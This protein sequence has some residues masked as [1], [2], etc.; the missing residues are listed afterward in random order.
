MTILDRVNA[1]YE[2][3]VLRVPPAVQGT[4]RLL[5]ERGYVV[6]IRRQRTGS[7]RYSMG[8]GRE[9]TAAQLIR[10]FDRLPRK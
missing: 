2:N 4:I 10:F 1:V 6:R 9:R 8:A 3:E 7:L 5:E